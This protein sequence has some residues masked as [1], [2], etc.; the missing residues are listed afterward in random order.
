MNNNFKKV[1]TKFFVTSVLIAVSSIALL[2]ASTVTWFSGTRN[3]IVYGDAI[4]ATGSDITSLTSIFYRSDGDYYD[5][6]N[7]VHYNADGSVDSDTFSLFKY[8]HL[9]KDNNME[10]NL[11]CKISL[12][13]SQAFSS[14]TKN[15][16]I[17][18]TI[19]NDHTLYAEHVTGSGD[20]YLSD[21]VQMSYSRI[22]SLALDASSTDIY[23]NATAYF[24][25]NSPTYSSFVSVSGTTATKTSDFSTSATCDL[26]STA[27]TTVVFYMNA[28]Y[29]EEAM[30][31]FYIN[32]LGKSTTDYT[33]ADVTLYGD[34]TYYVA[35]G[36]IS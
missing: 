25:N 9:I 15:I 11:I 21:V 20:Y 33:G 19:P 13:F 2:F 29:Y 4:K 6:Q 22:D 24:T 18:T 10:A 27:S 5:V 31:A 12:S 23:T 36:E 34:M 26:S 7:D 3:E 1:K 28:R 16:Q 35:L 14:S 17:K 32:A 8:D 30:D